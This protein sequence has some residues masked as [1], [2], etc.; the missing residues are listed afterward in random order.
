MLQKLVIS[1]S[2][3]Q[4]DKNLIKEVW[5]SIVDNDIDRS[6]EEISSTFKDLTEKPFFVDYHHYPVKGLSNVRNELLKRALA[7]NPDFII[8]VDDDEYVS[9]QWLNELVGKMTENNIDLAMGPVI[10][11]FEDDVPESISCWFKGQLYDNFRKCSPDTVSTANLI[12]NARTLSERKI[13]F[14]ERFNATG[15]EDSYFGKQLMRKGARCMWIPGAV[16][17]ETV[18]KE[19]S[20]IHWL[21]RRYFNGANNYT[22]ILRI[23]RQ[24]AHLAIKILSSFVDII[25]GIVAAPVLLL[26]L[27]KKYWGVLK[28]SEGI[29][30]IA[31]LLSIKY[32]EYK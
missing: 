10:S 14:D 12:L 1:I 19:R 7:R 6:A 21:V 8:F 13:W 24:Y 11:K 2:A 20:N 4:I 23:D 5:I 18:L 29:G 15:A 9:I 31:G 28:F 22:Y 16:V 30:V 25:T 17:Y 26:P 27:R 32:Y 3:S